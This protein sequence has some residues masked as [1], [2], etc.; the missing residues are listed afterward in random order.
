MI[1][2]KP[3]E[4]AIFDL[5][6]VVFG[7]SVENILKSWAKSMNISPQE[8]APKFGADSH[9]EHFETNDISPKQYREHVYET[10]GARLSDEEFDRGW[11][12][13]Y[14]GLLPGI[15]PLL[16]RLQQNLRLV[17]LTNTNSIHARDWRIR[18]ADIM[19]Y[20]ERVFA[21]HEIGVRKPEPKSFQVVLDYLDLDPG[22][23]AF[24]DDN[25]ENVRGAIAVGIKGFVATSPL[26]VSEKI[27]E[28]LRA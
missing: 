27:Q 4:A 13:I 18:Y 17:A 19:T 1:M 8:M 11:N 25:P 23:V 12:S 10:F 14:L 21:S 5:G 6:G 15:E 16:K 28:I 2:T 3:L 20:F 9:Y 24:F 7:I 22:K 26:E